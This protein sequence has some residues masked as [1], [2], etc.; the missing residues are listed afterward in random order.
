MRSVCTL[1]LFQP[2]RSGIHMP[3][4]DTWSGNTYG[5]TRTKILQR[6]NALCSAAVK[7]ELL[8]RDLSVVTYH[9]ITLVNVGA[10]YSVASTHPCLLHSV[11]V[12]PPS[13]TPCIS[14]IEILLEVIGSPGCSKTIFGFPLIFCNRTILCSQISH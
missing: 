1:L 6:G 7:T 8:C 5:V 13:N 12:H 2:R 10:I 9:K 4:L 11:S 3:V 14:P